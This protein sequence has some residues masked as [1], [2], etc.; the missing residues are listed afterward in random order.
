MDKEY[1]SKT[2]AWDAVNLAFNAWLKKHGLDNDA[3]VS[4]AQ[5]IFIRDVWK[6]SEINIKQTENLN[7]TL[8]ELLQ[9]VGFAILPDVPHKIIHLIVSYAGQAIDAEKALSVEDAITKASKAMYWCGVLDCLMPKRKYANKI[10]LSLIS[11]DRSEQKKENGNTRCRGKTIKRP[12]T[13]RKKFV[14]ECWDDWQKDPKK[15]RGKAVFVRDILTKV[16][17]LKSASTIE[18][19]CRKWEKEK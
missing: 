13:E 18:G 3:V 1:V 7:K 17:S 14:R 5:E 16:E 10:F 19:W 4:E 11:A 15:Y 9:D 2:V 12:Q 8:S 6:Q